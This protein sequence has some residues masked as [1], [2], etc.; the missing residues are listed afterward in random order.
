MN[1]QCTYSPSS[2]AGSAS[3]WLRLHWRARLSCATW[4][5]DALV[6]LAISLMMV[7]VPLG[8]TCLWGTL[9]GP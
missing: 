5:R 4:L 8:L 3:A 6:A 1:G 2:A 7:G 9:L